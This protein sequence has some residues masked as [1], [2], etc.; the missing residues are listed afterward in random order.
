MAAAV[1]DFRPA[2]VY[3]AKLPRSGG[4]VTIHL[5]PTEDI[6]ACLR[7]KKRDDQLVIAFAVE[8]I[9][10]VEAAAGHS[11]ILKNVGTSAADLE[12]IAAKARAEMAAKGADYVVVNTPAALAAEESRACIISAHGLVL[13]WA[14]RAKEKLAGEIVSL[15]G[16]M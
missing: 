5:M 2:K 14:A 11:N 12:R 15:L 13:P 16:R 8:D 10:P 3:P 9:E 1:G 7:E 6:L 4:P